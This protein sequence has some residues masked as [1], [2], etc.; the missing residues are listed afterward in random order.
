[1]NLKQRYHQ[2]A[3]TRLFKRNKQRGG[4]ASFSFEWLEP[5]RGAM[6]PG[7]MPV[8]HNQYAQIRG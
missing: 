2:D 1:M 6:T 7:Q 4:S 8:P 3:L 5:R